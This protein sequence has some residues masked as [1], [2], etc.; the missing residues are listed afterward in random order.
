MCPAQAAP[1]GPRSPSPGD[2]VGSASGWNRSDEGKGART[3]LSAQGQVSGC[4][5]IWLP[6][7]LCLGKLAEVIRQGT[8]GLASVEQ[9]T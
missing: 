6:L 5:S 9:G 4:P 7:R 2:A 8:V 3:V 1:D